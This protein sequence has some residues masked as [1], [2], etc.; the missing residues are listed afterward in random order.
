MVELSGYIYSC[1]WVSLNHMIPFLFKSGITVT[2][3]CTVKCSDFFVF[4]RR[5]YRSI[6]H[7]VLEW[8]HVYSIQSTGAINDKPCCEWLHAHMYFLFLWLNTWHYDV[9]VMV[10]SPISR[11]FSILFC[12]QLICSFLQYEPNGLSVVNDLKMLDLLWK[13]LFSH[14]DSRRMGVDIK[15]L[16]FTIM[17]CGSIKLG[18]IIKE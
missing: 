2:L 10:C 13:K 5:K 1:V 18:R 8:E 15:Q 16:D 3:L 12:L 11:L 17:S 14:T 6:K 7:L 4:L 9:C